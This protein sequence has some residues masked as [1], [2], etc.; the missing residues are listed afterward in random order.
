[1]NDKMQP[2]HDAKHSLTPAENAAPKELNK[3]PIAWKLVLGTGMVMGI[4][5][6]LVIA[7]YPKYT[8]LFAPLAMLFAIYS[9]TPKVKTRRYLS[10]FLASTIAGWLG[11]MGILIFHPDML[12]VNPGAPKWRDILLTFAVQFIPVWLMFSGFMSWFNIRVSDRAMQRRAKLLAERE[13]QKAAAKVGVT[14]R[15]KKKK[16]KKK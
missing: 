7:V 8:Q 10:V 3:G 9:I 13:A 16:K 4:L 1:M 12:V 6:F 2:M 5:A 11:W 14:H 15:K